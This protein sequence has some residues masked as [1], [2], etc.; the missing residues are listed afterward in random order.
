[1]RKDEYCSFCWRS[2]KEVLLL[3]EG[4][5]GFICDKCI[6]EAEKILQA[7]VSRRTKSKPRK[8]LM[9]PMEISKFLDSYIIGQQKAKKVLSVAV[10]NHFKRIY[11]RDYHELQDVEIEKSN[12]LMVGETGTGKT[13]LARTIARILDVPFCIADATVITEA[14]YVGEDVETVLTRLLQEAITLPLP[15]MYR[16]RAYSRRF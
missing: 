6:Q 15:V 12:I 11:S 1:M 8:E 10:Y 13:L 7:E 16:G 5:D 9:K 2:K 4:K 14:G 3:V